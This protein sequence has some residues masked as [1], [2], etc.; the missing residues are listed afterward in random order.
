MGDFDRHEG[1]ISL[2]MGDNLNMDVKISQV[3]RAWAR[4]LGARNISVAWG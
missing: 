3:S 2:V 1:K 4:L